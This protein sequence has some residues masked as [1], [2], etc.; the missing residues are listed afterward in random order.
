MDITVIGLSH[1]GAVAAASLAGAGH[2]VLGVDIDENRIALVQSG[3]I[4]FYEPGLKRILQSAIANRRL[5]FAHLDA[6]DQPLGEI[7]LIATSTPQTEGGAADLSQVLSAVRWIKAQRGRNTVIVMKSTVPPGTG[8]HINQHELRNVDLL[9]IA[10]PEFLREGQAVEDWK[11]PHRIVIGANPDDG[12]AIA[13]VKAMYADI[14]APHIITDITSAEMIKYASNAFLATRISFINEIAS[15]CEQV[16]ASIDAVSHGM[17]MDP[18][19]GGHIHAGVGDGGSCFPKDVRALDELGS[20]S[21]TD[22]ELLRAVINVNNRQRLLPLRALHQRFDDNLAGLR[23]AVLG[24]AFKPNT[25]D[26]RE[27]PSLDLIQALIREGAIVSAY[28]PEA[29]MA[30]QPHLPDSVQLAESVRAATN[31]AQAVVLITEWEQFVTAG[32]REIAHSMRAPRFIFDG[33]NALDAAKMRRLEFE[34]VGVGRTTLYG[35]HSNIRC[36]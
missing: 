11:N 22:M 3:T 26:V 28:D 23:V 2:H 7:A 27:A 34:Y 12:E 14:D 16:G 15:L 31:R 4:P 18:R 20:T 24:L 8:Q 17:A 1:V 30:A 33:R 29:M 21:G 5:R 10:N 36:N 32:W 6:V 9:Y 35:E 19:T 13:T 25:D